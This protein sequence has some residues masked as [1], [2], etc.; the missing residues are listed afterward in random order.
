[1]YYI[2][3]IYN[4]FV[5]TIS[6]PVCPEDLIACLKAILFHHL[7]KNVIVHFLTWA[8]LY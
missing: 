1:M 2:F 3:Y 4:Y 6:Y 8:R 7:L 5:V